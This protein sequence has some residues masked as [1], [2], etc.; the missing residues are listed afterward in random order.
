MGQSGLVGAE[1]LELHQL[2]S[3]VC[4]VL[5]LDLKALHCSSPDDLLV[6]WLRVVELVPGLRSL[7][8]DVLLVRLDDSCLVGVTHR[9]LTLLGTVGL[10]HGRNRIIIKVSVLVEI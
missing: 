10:V 4:Y 3:L 9:E 2:L 7:S 1:T 6:S 5:T 8:V